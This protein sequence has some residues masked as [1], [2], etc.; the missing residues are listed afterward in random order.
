MKTCH[1]SGICFYTK[2]ELNEKIEYERVA[3]PKTVPEMIAINEQQK[4]ERREKIAAREVEIAKNLEKLENW[5]KDI[6]MRKEKR[7]TV[8]TL[9]TF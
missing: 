5:K 2:Q 6:Q 1:F 4:R 3:F 8:R 9:S 7:E